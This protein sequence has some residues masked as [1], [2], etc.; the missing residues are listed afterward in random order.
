MA[1]PRNQKKRKQKKKDKKTP[2]A[3]TTVDVLNVS[4]PEPQTVPPPSEPYIISR[5][6]LEA[7]PFPPNDYEEHAEPCPPP[8]VPVQDPAEEPAYSQYP[9]YPPEEEGSAIPPSLL[10]TPFIHDPGNGPRVKDARA[11]LSSRFAAPP[12]VDD[13]L[14]AEFADEALA[15]MLCT[16]LPEETALVRST[17]E[18]SSSL[19]WS[20]HADIMVQQEPANVANMSCMP[21]TLPAR[22]YTSR[23]SIQRGYGGTQGAE[24]FTVLGK[25]AR[26][27]WTM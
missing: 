10:K 9:P 12:S 3:S 27:E 23:T 17:K 26:A 22:G 16:V 13:P 18:R 6:S 4:E 19:H 21:A 25:G 24:R 20:L 7:H 1:G 15:E 2:A 11:F 8:P 5:E 14:C